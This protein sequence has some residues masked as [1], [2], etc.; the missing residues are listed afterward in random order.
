[1]FFIAFVQ[2]LYYVSQ[3]QASLMALTPPQARCHAMGHR[4]VVSHF[5]VQVFELVLIALKQ[6]LGLLQDDEHLWRRSGRRLR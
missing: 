4:E 6:R 3:L 5:K 1:M 2:A